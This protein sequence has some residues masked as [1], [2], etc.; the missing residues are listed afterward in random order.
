MAKTKPEDTPDTKSETPKSEY[1]VS[2]KKSDSD[3][4]VNAKFT[5]GANLNESVALFGDNCVY[6]KFVQSAIIDL[7]SLMRRLLS[8]GKNDEEIK[9]EVAKWMPGAKT[10]VRKSG[11]EK[12]IDAL[13]SLSE[14]ERREILAQYS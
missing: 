6:S 4:V 3:R 13:G 1:E 10:T 11:K 2:A 8:A 9:A 12:A 14:E 7:Q 5:F